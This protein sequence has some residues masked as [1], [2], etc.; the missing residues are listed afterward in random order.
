MRINCEPGANCELSTNCEARTQCILTLP[1]YRHEP[2][3]RVLVRCSANWFRLPWVCVAS[4]TADRPGSLDDRVLGS[5]ESSAVRLR[6]VD[7]CS[8]R[9]DVGN[10]A[11]HSP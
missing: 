4:T 5:S 7:P 1:S 9:R 11:H 6:A 2:I 10:R 3:S 8:G